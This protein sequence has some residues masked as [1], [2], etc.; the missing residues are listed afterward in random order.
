M[1]QGSGTPP[2]HADALDTLQEALEPSSQA[3]PGR[4]E[5]NQ[6]GH[7]TGTF[8]TPRIGYTGAYDSF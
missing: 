7:A 4:R 3:V 2:P 1:Y 5:G 8:V 6:D